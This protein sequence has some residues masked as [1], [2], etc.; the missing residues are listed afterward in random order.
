MG[1]SHE[2]KATKKATRAEDRLQAFLAIEVAQSVFGVEAPS[3]TTRKIK[4]EEE[5]RLA[6]TNRRSVL[7]QAST[8]MSPEDA[9]E[10]ITSGSGSV[11][12]LYLGINHR[13]I[14]EDPLV[15][16]PPASLVSRVSPTVTPLPPLALAEDAESLSVVFPT[17]FVRHRTQA[18]LYRKNRLRLL[19]VA[20]RQSLLEQAATVLML[21][22]TAESI[23]SM[24][25]DEPSVL[26]ITGSGSCSELLLYSDINH[27]TGSYIGNT[28]P[29]EVVGAAAVGLTSQATTVV[30]AGS[31][32]TKFVRH[33][34]QAT[35][36][37]RKNRK[38]MTAA[39]HTKKGGIVNN[40]EL[41]TG[42][43]S[44]SFRG[45]DIGLNGTGVFSAG[46]QGTDSSFLPPP[47]ALASDSQLKK[48]KSDECNESTSGAGDTD[49]DTTIPRLN[50]QALEF[51]FAG[52]MPVLVASLEGDE[53]GRL[54]SRV[55][56]GGRLNAHA[57]EFPPSGARPTTNPPKRI[58]ASLPRGGGRGGH[59]TSTDKQHSAARGGRNAHAGRHWQQQ[60]RASDRDRAGGAKV[61]V[62]DERASGVGSDTA[63]AAES[64]DF[65][66]EGG[67]SSTLAS[68][69]ASST[70]ASAA[71]SLSS[72][73]NL[74]IRLKSTTTTT[75]SLPASP[76]ST[77]VSNMRDH[78]RDRFIFFYQGLQEM[79]HNTGN[80]RGF[81]SS[82]LRHKKLNI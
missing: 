39:N 44:S 38:L 80:P 32:S 49:F 72:S 6:A 69:S 40:H 47:L 10:G 70:S 55:G 42:S 29:A 28:E 60:P 75:T 51:S 2:K 30:A 33:K 56:G 5:N 11:S 62:D 59:R 78:Q 23:P 35:T 61:G 4:R 46:R 57:P 18:K 68:A 25:N 37:S 7:P 66:S 27:H 8:M 74:P 24:S 81:S 12:E 1:K 45:D 77:L 53:N 22:G 50:A 65:V 67:A 21:P 13:Y 82:I 41:N 52:N 17:K 71:E 58:T 73:S 20:N 63:A 54:N 31:S 43:S 14:S 3:R 15:V 26:P 34:V 16:A 19:A 64:H 79:R 76:P 9:E 48:T 36:T